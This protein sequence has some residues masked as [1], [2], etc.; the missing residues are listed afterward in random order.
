MGRL[1]NINTQIEKIRALK[2]VKSS[3]YVSEL[4]ILEKRLND[5][6]FRLVV[7]GEFSSGKSTFINAIIGRDILKHAATETTATVTY[8]YNVSKDD[9]RINT[10]DIEYADGKI[11][12]LPDLE[13]LRQ[14]TT[15]E[16]DIN[17][18]EDIKSVSIY[19]CFLDVKYPV[20]IV[21]TPGLNGIA[22][23]H[24][25]ITLGEIKKAHACIYL[26]SSNGVK[27]SD[28]DFIKV[29]LNYQ[30]RFIFIQNFIDLLR[31]SE[32]ESFQSKINKDEEILRSCFKNEGLVFEY[33]I[34]GISAVKALASKD[35]H[36]LKVFED[37]KNEI[38]DRKK[39]YDESNIKDFEDYVCKLVES[40][41]YLNV[42]TDSVCYT[43]R[44]IIERVKNN[45]NEECML[46][47]QLRKKDEQ[48]KGIDKAKEIIERIKYQR[49]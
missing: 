38:I 3:R 18:A 23:K 46:S 5:K 24:R 13:K 29:L 25:E 4:D 43:L 17:V 49:D 6:T 2:A 7:V 42:I 19:V 41:E 39:L 33:N 28:K 1:D 40:E 32:G 27:A 44:Q 9:N 34:F 22:D 21:D 48:S 45:L 14:Y 10:C 26:L 20:V 37:D 31:V 36:K 47:E 11:V 35:I 30:K 16:S 12:N 8:I 15:V